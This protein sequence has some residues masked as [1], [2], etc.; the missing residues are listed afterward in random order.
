[1]ELIRE[2]TLRA[3]FGESYQVGGGPAGSRAVVTLTGGTVEGERI[4][5]TLVGPGADWAIL[6]G[7]GYAQIDVRTQIRTA[8]G[9]D[10][11]LQYQGLLELNDVATKA[12]FGD[13]ETA[14]GDNYWFTSMRMEAGAERYAWVNRTMFVG[15]GR[16]LSDGIE[17]EVYRLA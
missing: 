9:A 10:L 6:R 7:D 3:T 11:F 2:F 1:M 8:D 5:G 4:S 17:Y 14:F 15:Q 13:G 16:A 12:L